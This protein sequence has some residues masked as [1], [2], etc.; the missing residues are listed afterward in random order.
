MSQKKS[1][2]KTRLNKLKEIIHKQDHLYYIM[3]QPQI[4]DYKY[5]Q[6][7]LELLKL[8][9]QYP[10]LVTANSPSQRV[11]GKALSRFKKAKHKKPMLSLQ[12][13]Y[14]EKEIED[15]Y[16]K[17]LKALETKEVYFLLEPKLDGVG[18]N[19]LYKKGHLIQALTRGDGTTG[20]NVFENIKTIRSIPLKIDLLAEIL[21]VR[22]E[23]VLL[24]EDFKK[25]N[26]KQEEQ[27]LNYF[28]NP[29]NMAAGSLRQLDPAVTAQ[30]PLKFFTHCLGFYKGTKL[31]RQSEFL[32]KAA[33]LNLPV[34]PVMNL[35]SFKDKNKKR[36]QAGSVLCKSQEEI[37]EYLH[38]LEKIKHQ[39][40]FETDGVVVKVDHFSKQ[41][42]LGMTSRSPRWARAAK[43]KPEIGKTLVENIFIQVGRTGVLT[44]VAHLRP[45]KLGGVIITHAT[46]HNQSEIARKDVR[47]GDIVEI[48]RAGDVI[49]EIIQVDFSK[50]RKSRK[51]QQFKMPNSCPECQGKVQEIRNIVFCINPLCPAV[52]LNSLIHFASKKAMNIVALGRKIIQKL[53]EEKLI[54]NFSDIYKLKKHQLLDLERMGEKSS[55]R[56]LY[57]IEKSKEV[58][59]ANFIF[60]LGIKHVGEQTAHN[61]SDFFTK[62]LSTS[63]L[64]NGEK[65]FKLIYQ[66][67]EEELKEVSDIGSTVA[68]SL[69]ETFSRKSFK[70]ELKIL[71]RQGLKLKTPRG[72]KRA[73]NG[74][75]SGK[76]L[77]LT[78][79]L[80]LPRSEVEK[81]IR[82]LGG[83]IQSSVN[84]N[85]NFLL[86]G[87]GSKKLS[88]KEKQA[89]KQGTILLD[90]KAFKKQVSSGGGG[91]H[92]P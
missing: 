49:P 25:I 47:V 5:D 15:F 58:S 31:E 14:S 88:R 82:S 19:L 39:L 35:K 67:T 4:S 92:L 90:W 85:T 41:E 22:G 50:R 3:D 57:S 12:N 87:E 7:F 11:P 69:R 20:E 72:T 76:N 27:G 68:L 77:V 56:I 26:K 61:L 38:I 91:R 84:K 23:I 70:D 48:G 80:P 32:K 78:G 36:P 40:P 18:I 28:A 33:T 71:L 46:L 34:F 6:I 60:A 89:Q 21:E 81:L 53:Y 13:T 1:N 75:F 8:E 63:K 44:P 2:I 16:T 37:L 55:D 42:K 29:R 30:R 9:E 17:T 86:K 62:K 73:G 52:V 45:V 54:Q 83:Q 79:T 43:F 66:A 24:K 10:D 65:V 64:K 51:V 74:M 59:L